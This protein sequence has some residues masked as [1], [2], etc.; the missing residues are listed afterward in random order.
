M[1]IKSY[2][3]ACILTTLSH[4]NVKIEKSAGIEK[5]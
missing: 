5:F 4:E 2:A 1:A 3:Y